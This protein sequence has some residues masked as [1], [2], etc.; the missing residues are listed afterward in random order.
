MP[1]PVLVTRIEVGLPD[2][3]T[4]RT[5]I[6][7]GIFFPWESFDISGDATTCTL[8]GQGIVGSC[9]SRNKALRNRIQAFPR[10]EDVI[11]SREKTIFINILTSIH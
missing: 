10:P 9:A 11:T 4:E 6:E 2:S 7:I 3:S 1:L 5:V 8:S